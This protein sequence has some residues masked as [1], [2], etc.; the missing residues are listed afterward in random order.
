MILLPLEKLSILATKPIFTC[1]E[2]EVIPTSCDSA[3]RLGV[4]ADLFCDKCEKGKTFTGKAYSRIELGWKYQ[5]E[6]NTFNRNQYAPFLENDI[7]NETVEEMIDECVLSVGDAVT[8]EL[9]CPTCGSLVYICY[10]IEFDGDQNRVRNIFDEA[11]KEPDKYRVH[12]IGEYPNQEPTRFAHLVKYKDEFSREY[13]FLLKAEKAYYLQLGSGSII[14]L[15]KAYESLLY[16]VL[17]EFGIERPKQFKE[18]LRKADEAAKIVPAELTDRAYGLFG[19]M[20][21]I[22]HGEVADEVG[23]KKYE[24]LRDV[25]GIILDNIL[26][27]R[28]RA[29]L[30]KRIKYDNKAKRNTGGGKDE[31]P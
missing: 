4:S 19:E 15:R 13:A 12:K 16:G 5:Q 30:V 22:S 29:D 1:T 21:D 11:N 6:N 25:L 3:N 24:L 10:A 18:A 2:W 23:L 28:K 31:Q 7:E 8:V 26:E 14:Y 20:S 17:D 9:K 27:K